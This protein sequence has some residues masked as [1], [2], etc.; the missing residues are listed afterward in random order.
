MM[1]LR[2]DHVSLYALGLEE[3]TPLKVWVERGRLPEPDDDLAADMYELAS[4]LLGADGF[5]QYEISNWARP[6]HQCR[7]NLQYWHNDPYVGVGPG[8]HGW[9]GGV[10]YATVLSAAALH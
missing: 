4:D 2:P 10:R 3:G 1:A 8:A 7:H 5:E 6:G 9:A